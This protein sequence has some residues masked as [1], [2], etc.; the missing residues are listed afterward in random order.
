MSQVV[1]VRRAAESRKRLA[2]VSAVLLAVAACAAIAVSYNAQAASQPSIESMYHMWLGPNGLPLSPRKQRALLFQ[3]CT[4]N[5]VSYAAVRRQL[6]VSSDIIL[7]SMPPILGELT[8]H[9]FIR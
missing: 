2:V 7:C 5:F 6:L 4:T 1:Q 8:H 3:F 9:H